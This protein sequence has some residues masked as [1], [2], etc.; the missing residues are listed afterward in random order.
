MGERSMDQSISN[1]NKRL[2]F[3]AAVNQIGVHPFG[4][5]GVRHWQSVYDNCL[6]LWRIEHEVYDMPHEDDWFFWNFA[7]LHDCCRMYDS[8]DPGHPARAAKL[9]PDNDTDFNKTLRHAILGHS[10]GKLSTNLAV[11][12]CWD[13]D[14]LDLPRVGVV[15]NPELMSTKAG[16]YLAETYGRKPE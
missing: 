16:K 14:R 12:I 11:A 6:N 15:P 13:A 8:S 5:H 9:I 1:I 2:I 3:Q 4:L 7:M 10:N